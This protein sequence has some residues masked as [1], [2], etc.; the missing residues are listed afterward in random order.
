MAEKPEL[1]E[2]D[3]NDENE[4]DLRGKLLKRLVVA[5]I[6]VAVLL[7]VLAFFDYLSSR[8]VD[9]PA[10]VFTK[11]VPVPPKKEITQPVTP[12]VSE[13][14]SGSVEPGKVEGISSSSVSTP[15]KTE[16]EASR[17][18]AAPTAEVKPALSPTQAVSPVPKGAAAKPAPAA[19]AGGPVAVAPKKPAVVPEST[20][21][22]VAVQTAPPKTT[23]SPPAQPPSS[24]QAAPAPTSANAQK[25]PQ[26]VIVA[27]PS[28]PRLLTG[29]VV[30]AGVFSNA[31]AAEELHAKLALNGIQSTLEARVQIGPFKTKEEA[32]AARKKL[33]ELGID[34]LLIPPSGRR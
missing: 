2:N 7:G 24:P 11:P 31:R 27:P 6:L 13:T 5:G 15:D 10:K 32:E 34:G 3:E 26:P 21:A 16:S 20:A 30:Q 9:T 17:A 8:R 33:K 28:L 14:K 12:A 25:P 19:N 18:P 1:N 29:F 22:P 4:W 23:A